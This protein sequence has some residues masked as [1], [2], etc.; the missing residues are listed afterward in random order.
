MLEIGSIIDGKYKIL[1]EIGRG[2]M[3]IVYLAIN[4]KANK[5]WA[6]KEIRKEGVENYEVIKQSQVVETDMLKKLKH[7]NL[8]SIVDIID[9][10][11]SF[12][13]V[14]DY[15]EGRPLSDAIKAY[16]SLPCED[17]VEWAKQLCDVLGYLHSRTPAIIYRD[18]KPFNIMLQPDGMVKLIDFGTAR[19]YKEYNN[20]DTTCLGTRGYAAPEQFGG[21]GQTDA[22]TDIYCLG[23][24]IYHLVTGHNPGEPPYE[25]YPI[26]HWDSTLSSGLE[27]IIL[28]CT[29]M[30]PNDRYQSCAELTYALEHYEEEDEDYKKKENT[31]WRI[32]ILS[33]VLTLVMGCFS[34]FFRFKANEKI[35]D[36]YQENINAAYL[37]TSQDDKLFYYQNAIEINP[38]QEEA[39]MSFLDTLEQDG[40]F[41]EEE[42]KLVREL[43]PKY[44][45]KIQDNK[46]MYI[47]IAYELGIMYFYYYENSEDTQ[48]AEKW[49]NIAVGNTIDHISD[50]D[51]DK[52]LT[53]KKAFRARKLY[54]IL[55]YYKELNVTNLAGDSNSTYLQLWDDLSTIIT[56]NIAKDDNNVTALVMYNFMANQL[57]MNAQNFGEAEVSQ[58]VMYQMIDMME[59][60]VSYDANDKHQKSLYD[61]LIVNLEQARLSV[62]VVKTMGNSE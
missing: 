40:I 13:I 48:N 25:M 34:M 4:E 59:Q 8:P 58:E 38:K 27:K 6:I 54:A 7:P 5:P 29:Q 22:R 10:Q 15:I 19:E 18:M 30:N 39:Y 60:S 49:L 46:E 47:K 32:F 52:I 35:V 3:S 31:K 41:T 45:D 26:R 17:V 14:M 2:G 42:S 23:A 61:R 44:M 37:A 1:S 57:V 51:I 28:K 36:L 33:I 50:E 43:F 16:G 62:N 53:S 11:D 20:A 24:T 12:L 21:Q 9:Q 55:K 56:P